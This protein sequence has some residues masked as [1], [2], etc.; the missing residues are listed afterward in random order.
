VQH[1]EFGGIKFLSNYLPNS[2]V[3]LVSLSS[4]SLSPFL[5]GRFSLISE[6]L[7]IYFVKTI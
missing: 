5:L 6:G 2:G 4:S 3:T 7:I 1:T